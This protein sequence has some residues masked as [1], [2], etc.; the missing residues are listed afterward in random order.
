MTQELDNLV[1][2]AAAGDARARE[3]LYPLL[4]REDL[5]VPTDNEIS[6]KSEG[7]VEV[8]V[9]CAHDQQGLLSVGVFTSTEALI[10]W[11][12]KGCHY[13]QAPGMR[14]FAMLQAMPIERV[15]LN[16]GNESWIMLG[17]I[18]IE[19]MGHG[20]A[21]VQAAQEIDL[22]ELD[23]I[24]VSRP[25]TPLSQE[26]TTAL[27]R[28]I[29]GDTRIAFAYLPQIQYVHG[30]LQQAAITLVL[31]PQSGINEFQI[32]D[33]INA[34]GQ[35]AQDL[36]PSGQAIDV[37]TLPPSHELLSLVMKTGCMLAVNDEPYHRRILDTFSQLWQLSA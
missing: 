20:N 32:E 9:L 7:P 16:W 30:E 22:P 17:R 5:I 18:E 4:L 37:M 10:R 19:A 34:I 11:N 6:P 14:V 36:V 26:I 13:I 31:V 33:A 35:R 27:R 23:Q 2:A 1:N 25:K 12:P 3:K 29:E 24:Q 8:N 28:L 21:Q 15:Y